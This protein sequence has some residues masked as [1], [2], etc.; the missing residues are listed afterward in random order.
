MCRPFAIYN[1]PMLWYP[2]L[3]LIS[4]VQNRLGPKKQYHFITI[5]PHPD[6]ETMM[7]GGTI[8]KYSKDNG[9]KWTLVSLTR[10][11]YGDELMPG[12]A[13]ETIAEVRTEELIKAAQCLG[14]KSIV[15]GP[16][17]DG[18]L[19]NEKDSLRN[20]LEEIAN[21]E[22]PDLVITYEHDGIYGHP[23]HIMT[24]S[25]VTEVFGKANVPILYAT[26]PRFWLKRSRLPTH[27]AD[28]PSGLAQAEP[29]YQVTFPRV[30]WRKFKA[31]L[32]HKSQKLNH[33]VPLW[34]RTLVF[35]ME[36]YSTRP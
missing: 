16:F 4:F 22:K 9:V 26:F 15:W 27:M 5:F 20:F 32:C 17:I 36:Y 8:A 19:R 3:D 29:E 30:G 13:P 21:K 18:K 14:T 23:D 10:G 24:S 7:C 12:S 6:D 1:T 31:A 28:D 35:P 33:D 34:V 2:S 25:V 11:E